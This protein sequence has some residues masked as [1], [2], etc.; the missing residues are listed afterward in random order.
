[1]SQIHIFHIY[2]ALIIPQNRRKILTI[3]DSD[4]KNK[5]RVSNFIVFNRFI[6]TLTSLGK[7]ARKNP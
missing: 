6:K 4:R 7:R 3:K 5:I 2:Y 1:M